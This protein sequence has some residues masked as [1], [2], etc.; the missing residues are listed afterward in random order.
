MLVVSRCLLG[1]A[2]EANFREGCS[3]SVVVM[4]PLHD[5]AH[6]ISRYIP[7]EWCWDELKRIQDPDIKANPQGRTS[8]GS[9]VLVGGVRWL[10][11]L[12]HEA[13]PDHVPIGRA[14]IKAP[15]D[16]VAKWQVASF[17]LHW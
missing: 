3:S 10:K 4:V 15:L 7:V 6:G 14:H 2:L 8:R 5:K 1:L 16:V 9:A 11:S 13:E 12:V 17:A